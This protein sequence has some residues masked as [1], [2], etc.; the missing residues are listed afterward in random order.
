MRARPAN[1]SSKSSVRANPTRGPSSRS[2]MPADC[3][4]TPPPLSSRVDKA[5]A[6]EPR[7][8]QALIFKADH[9]A[10]LGDDR[11]ASSHYQFAVRAAPPAD[12]LAPE[13]RRELDRA[14]AMGERYARKFEQFLLERLQGLRPPGSR[15]ARASNNRSTSCS[16]R[17][18]S[19]SSSRRRS[20]FRNCRRS[21]STTAASSPGST[22][23]RPRPARSAASSSELL[24]GPLRIPALR[25]RRSAP[26][27]QGTVAG[28]TGNPDWSAFYLWKNGRIVPENIARCPKT[29]APLPPVPFSEVSNRSPSVLFSLLRPGARIPA[30]FGPRQYP[31]DLPPAADRSAGLR[32]SRRQRHAHAGRRQGL[33]VRRHDRAR[34]LEQQRPGPR[35]PAVRGLASG[36]DRRGA[37]PRPR[38]VRRHRCVQRAAAVLEHL[39]ARGNADMQGLSHQSTEIDALE[40]TA[41]QAAQSGREADAVRHWSRILELD[42]NHLRAL[43]ALGQ[44]A[45]RQGDMPDARAAFQRIVDA[46][47][48]IAAA[49]DPAGRSRAATCT[50]TR[51]RMQ[52]IQ[53]ALSDR[54]PRSGGPDPPRPTLLE[55]KGKM[56]EAS[57][58]L[59]RGRGG[60][61]ADAAAAART[62][63]GR[64]RGERPCG[65]VQPGQ[66]PVP[67]SIPRSALP[68]VC[69][70][71]PAP[72]PHL[73]RHHGRAQEAL[74]LA[75]DDC[76]TFRIWRRSSSST[77]REFPWLDGVEA[78]DRR[79]PR[80][81]PRRASH[82]RGL[83]ALHLVSAR[84]AAQPVR[85]AQQFAALE[86]VPPVQVRAARGC[87]R[88]RVARRPWRCWNT[89]R[90]RTS[91]DEPPRR[92]SRC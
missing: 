78:G 76:T 55:R 71:G 80:R 24:E 51:R 15:P 90:S 45:F 39:S 4:A 30:A 53:S 37:R 14:R 42:P 2:R 20:T 58:R 68:D 74:R 27:A 87:Q 50:T 9:L 34:S 18:T 23:S 12:G 48:T 43:N 41:M 72:V 83:H 46:D 36:T 85:G 86:R 70:R 56:H 19:T 84:G 91:R 29:A 62:A 88:E 5:L 79:H 59:W 32:L 61:S 21:S 69:R 7:N 52:A 57:R 17:R 11:A 66:G 38:D 31:P 89:C 60:R 44:R 3:L 35:H 49:M 28:C 25:R 77:A 82:R 8:F 1:R 10:A 16:A 75:V 22:R 26:A 63:P 40:A 13:L 64:R 47:G 54:S 92:C 65:E 81:I 73:S 67:R 6:L 33:G